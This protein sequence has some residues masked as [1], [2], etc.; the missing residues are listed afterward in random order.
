DE[1]PIWSPDGGR[2]VFASSRN[3][4][5]DLYQKPADGSTDEQLVYAS[6]EPKL[7]LSWSRDGRFLLFRVDSRGDAS[8]A[9]HDLWV[10]PLEGSHKPIPYIRTE[11]NESDGS[12]SPDGH[13]VAYVSN[14]SG[15]DE[16]YVR[17]FTADRGEDSAASGGKWMVSQGGG[18]R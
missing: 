7:P 11:F 14:E 17:A 1:A 2:I 8:S 3:G 18:L 9:N 15:R 13:W 5:S 16:V 4:V 6:R 10:L 12:F